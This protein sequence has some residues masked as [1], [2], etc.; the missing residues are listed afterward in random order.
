MS[1][2]PIWKSNTLMFSL[3]CLRWLALGK[4][5]VPC[6]RFH[7]ISSW[8]GDLRYSAATFFKA[9]SFNRLRSARFRNATHG[10]AGL[11]W[12]LP[13]RDIADGYGADEPLF[14]VYDGQA[15][16][17]KLCH[18]FA[19]MAHVLIAIAVFDLGGHD[20]ADHGI[21]PAACGDGS[22]SDVAVGDHAN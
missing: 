22:E 19:D 14:A 4:G 17:L 16:H 13:A 1:S 15:A 10:F 7:R 6:C 5:T 2:S 20:Y 9:R 8:A 3:R 18:A 12:C 21:G 11:L